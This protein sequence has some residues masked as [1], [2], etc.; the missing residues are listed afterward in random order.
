MSYYTNSET[1]KRIDS[2]LEINARIQA[3]LGT[4]SAY[5]IGSVR[6]AD[7]MWVQFLVEIHGL[8]KDYYQQIATSEEKEM[9]SK[10]IYNKYR[11]RLERD[12][13]V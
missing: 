9:V 12:A 11:Y 5:D 13:A 4:K 8:D 2:L 1:R 7:Q 6:I 3:N 10:K